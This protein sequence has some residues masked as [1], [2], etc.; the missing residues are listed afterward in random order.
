MLSITWNSY[1]CKTLQGKKNVSF[2]EDQRKTKT[3]SLYSDE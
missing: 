2:Q 3:L 1:S